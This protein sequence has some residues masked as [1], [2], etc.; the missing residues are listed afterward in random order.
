[1]F[2]GIDGFHWSFGHVLFLSLFFA[3]AL[4]ILVTVASSAWRA[5]QDFRN[6]RAI[7]LW[8]RSQFAELPLTDR[9]C[10][11]EL[12]GRVISRT[13][14]N[15]FDCRHCEKYSQ[16]AVLPA[17]GNVSSTGL[18]YSRDRYYHRGHT[19]V[20]PAH[21]GTVTVGLDELAIH[22]V[23]TPDSIAMPEVGE[24]I[25]LNQ[26]A[27]RMKKNGREIQVRAPIE[28]TVMAIGSAQEGWYLRMR[29]R[30]DLRE[31]GTLRHLLRGPEVHG[32]LTR[33]LER[34]QL[35]LRAPNTPAAL[36]DGGVLLPELM[37]V[38]PEADWETVL[39][40]TFLQA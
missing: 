36:A 27:W 19:W 25:E 33:E 29:P 6:H 12:A 13:C 17:T 35:Q 30:L 23:G 20:E 14:D 11:H 16:F 37:N 9:R 1:M 18:E 38:I 5:T 31:P 2:P 15:A 40:D 22:L 34:L 21:D 4:T 8:W 32:W 3:V 39:A 26:T 7:D 24:E 28:G 10:R